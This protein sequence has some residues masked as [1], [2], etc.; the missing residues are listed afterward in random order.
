MN[1]RSPVAKPTSAGVKQRGAHVDALSDSVS[2]CSTYALIVPWVSPSRDA[3]SAIASGTETCVVTLTPPLAA[4]AH[5][6][7]EKV[8]LAMR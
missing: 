4:S 5:A 1:A 6:D 7:A 2:V 8:A 3:P